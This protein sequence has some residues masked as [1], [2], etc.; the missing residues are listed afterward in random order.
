MLVFK[1]FT[2]VYETFKA[3]SQRKPILLHANVCLICI[4]VLI[5]E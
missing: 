2:I 4:S 5:C 1:V 3:F